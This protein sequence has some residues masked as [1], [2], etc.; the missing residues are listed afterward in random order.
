[1]QL[2]ESNSY[3]LSLNAARLPFRHGRNLVPGD[4]VEPPPLLYRLRPAHDDGGGG[5]RIR[6]YE[7][8][9]GQFY[10]LLPLTAR[11]PLRSIQENA[12]RLGAKDSNL[13]HLGQN[14]ASCR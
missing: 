7:L 9:R 13:D 5:G 4:G 10:R 8:Q 11:P 2:R 6:T 3:E 1:V 12:F 14:Q